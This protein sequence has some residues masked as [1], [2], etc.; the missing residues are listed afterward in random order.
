MPKLTTVNAWWQKCCRGLDGDLDC[1]GVIIIFA[2]YFKIMEIDERYMRRALQLAR[3]GEGAVSPNPMVG[4]VIVRHGLII[5]EGYHRQWGGPHAEVNA[6]NSVAD[7]RLLADS[8]MYVTL[9]PCSHYGKTPPC[10]ELLVRMR[11][12][13]VVVG[14]TDPFAKVHGRGIQMLRDAGVEVVTGVLADECRSLNRRFVTAHTAKRP[15]IMLK[16]AQSADG[17]IDGLRTDG[18]NTPVVLS[19]ALSMMWM[20]RERSRCDAILV[21]AGTVTAD[22]PS[23]TVRRWPVA[24]RQPLRVVLDGRLSMPASSKLLTDGLPTIIYNSVKSG[25]DGCVEYVKIDSADA[26]SWLSHLYARGITSLMVEG[27]RH[28]L[29]ELIDCGMWDEARVETALA[30]TL[31]DGVPAPV[32][33]GGTVRN[34]EKHWANS[35]TTLVNDVKTE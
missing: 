13:R 25:I 26:M 5:G 22:D 16:W 33:K 29:E 12:P 15:Y 20:H 31:G 27:G 32:L 17:Y 3:L 35:V 9:E 24:H 28:L 21:G 4:A 18:C 10:A 34:I 11:V 1:S 23:L 2:S 19:N 30:M 8:T 6:V 7:K 14:M